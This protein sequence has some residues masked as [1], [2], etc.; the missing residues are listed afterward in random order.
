MVRSM[1]CADIERFESL[2]MLSNF[3]KPQ[4]AHIAMIVSIVTLVWIKLVKAIR[5]K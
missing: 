5:E 1:G 2:A 4:E 3:P